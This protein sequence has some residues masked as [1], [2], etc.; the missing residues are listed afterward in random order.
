VGQEEQNITP[1]NDGDY[2]VIG[3]VVLPSSNLSAF[4]PST[5]EIPLE[6]DDDELIEEGEVVARVPTVPQSKEHKGHTLTDYSTV[7]ELESLV[8]IVHAP[9]VRVDIEGSDVVVEPCGRLKSPQLHIGTAPP[10]WVSIILLF[11]RGDVTQ[12]RYYTDPFCH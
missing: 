8:D 12:A 9:V 5:G 4:A 7:E 1:A 11:G 6:G 2:G 3:R 10:I